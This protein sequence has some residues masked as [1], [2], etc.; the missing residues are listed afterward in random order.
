M[1]KCAEACELN[2]ECHYF[3]L[4]DSYQDRSCCLKKNIPDN[5][6]NDPSNITSTSPGQGGKLYKFDRTKLVEDED[7]INTEL[8]FLHIN[9]LLE[10]SEKAKY[11]QIARNYIIGNNIDCERK[12]CGGDCNVFIDHHTGY[13]VNSLCYTE[14]DRTGGE[15]NLPGTGT[16]VAFNNTYDSGRYGF[17]DPDHEWR[18]NNLKYCDNYVG[19]RNAGEHEGGCTHA[20]VSDWRSGVSDNIRR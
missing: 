12:C 8:S 17:N 10:T 9:T 7:N 11:C 13:D 18:R 4:Y 14:D 1:S 6:I 19:W 5:V 16:C 2:D 3:W 15:N 20:A